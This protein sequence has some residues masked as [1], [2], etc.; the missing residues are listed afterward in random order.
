MGTSPRRCIHGI[1]EQNFGENM[2]SSLHTLP[3]QHCGGRAM[4]LAAGF[5]PRPYGIWVNKITLSLRVLLFPL[6]IL[7]PL[8]APHSII[9][10]S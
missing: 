4:W 5:D 3:H 9:I 7:M 6:P 10:P 1:R 8:T 2:S